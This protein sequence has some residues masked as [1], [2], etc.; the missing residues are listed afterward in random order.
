M[1]SG[2]VTWLVL[3][4][5]HVGKAAKLKKTEPTEWLSGVRLKKVTWTGFG[6]NYGQWR[7]RAHNL[8]EFRF[9]CLL[10]LIDDNVNCLYANIIFW[11]FEAVETKVSACTRWERILGFMAVKCQRR[12]GL[13]GQVFGP[14]F[15]P[16]LA[17][18]VM[19][20]SN[21]RLNLYVFLQYSIIT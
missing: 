5:A 10:Y 14:S 21:C 11:Q 19:W 20:F 4:I 8:C 6:L 15:T 16:L 12:R 17:I 9:L 3:A 7:N 1:D 18:K 2:I 13:F